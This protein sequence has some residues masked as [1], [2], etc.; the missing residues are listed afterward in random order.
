M[1]EV[2]CKFTKSAGKEAGRVVLELE[3]VVAFVDGVEQKVCVTNTDKKEAH[4]YQGEKVI[5]GIINIIFTPQ[6]SV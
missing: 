2:Y 1:Q 3:D 6:Q 5:D 4:V